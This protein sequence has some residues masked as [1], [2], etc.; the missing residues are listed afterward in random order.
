MAWLGP[1]AWDAVRGDR[2][3]AADAPLADQC[4]DVPDSASRL[5]LT[6][7]DGRALGAASV[8]DKGART[9][10]ALRHGASQTLC[11]WLSWADAL[12]EETGTRVLLFDRRSQGSSPG[13]DDLAPEPDDVAAAVALARSEGAEEIVL[14]ASSMGNDSTWNALP[15]IDGEACGVISI[16]P[17]VAT[18][19]IDALDPSVFPRAVFAIHEDENASIVA[20]AEHLL[21]RAAA[22]NAA[23]VAIP[24]ATDDHSLWLVEN[25]DDAEQHVTEGVAS[26]R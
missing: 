26:C 4:G 11:D 5:T 13:D 12:A 20:T 7:R 23:T 16:S 24:V 22:A 17:V 2:A 21:K 1:K 3:T 10:V 9:T 18:A 19:D 25:H 14:V 8:G 6:A 15:R